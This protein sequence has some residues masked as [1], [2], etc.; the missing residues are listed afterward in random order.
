MDL[1][2]QPIR[3]VV[4]EGEESQ[5]VTS[6]TGGQ[7]DTRQHVADLA[8]D[9]LPIHAR[10]KL[11]SQIFN[12]VSP[13]VLAPVGLPLLALVGLG[14]RDVAASRGGREDRRKLLRARLK[15]AKDAGE[16]EGVLR[17]AL[18]IALGC[19]AGAVDRARIEAGLEDALKE[20]AL[21]IYGDLEEARY[22][23]GAIDEGLAARV[24][25]LANKL[26]GAK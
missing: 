6:Y 11:G 25:A 18:G 20:E 21:A 26:L 14:L 13:A 12:P 19:P 15:T 16:L 10:P 1:S 4:T 3:L 22:G 23:G 17:E 5:A 8:D 24:I 7:V 9:I 2:T